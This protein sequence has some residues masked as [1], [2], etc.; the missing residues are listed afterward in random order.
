MALITLYLI[1]HFIILGAPFSKHCFKG[2]E[3]DSGV[4]GGRRT[5]PQ[6]ALGRGFHVERAGGTP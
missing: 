5:R 1:Y 4:G 6:A 2:G 3:G